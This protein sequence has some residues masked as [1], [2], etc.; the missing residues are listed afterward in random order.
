M[1]LLLPDITGPCWVVH[2]YG[3]ESVHGVKVNFNAVTHAVVWSSLWFNQEMAQLQMDK[4]KEQQQWMKAH[5]MPEDPPPS[6]VRFENPRAAISAMA[7]PP[8][9]DRSWEGKRAVRPNLPALIRT[10]VE[11]LREK[12]ASHTW[13]QSQEGTWITIK[14]QQLLGQRQVKVP[15]KLKKKT[16][17]LDLTTNVIAGHEAPHRPGSLGIPRS[18]DPPMPAPPIQV[19]TAGLILTHSGFKVASLTTNAVAPYSKA[20]N[21]RFW[22]RHVLTE[23]IEV[24]EPLRGLWAS[25]TGGGFSSWLS[26]PSRLRVRC[27]TGDELRFDDNDEKLLL[28]GKW[29]AVEIAAKRL[30]NT[31]WVNG[32]N[33]HLLDRWNPEPLGIEMESSGA[34]LLADVQ[35][36]QTEPTRTRPRLTPK[37][38]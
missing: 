7:N 4:I 31:A 2:H 5:K 12:Q 18:L 10:R 3:H 23:D 9:N 27:G 1:G 22:I 33:R 6:M 35:V 26:R 14:G 36:L 17:T 29:H 24:T 38:K 19:N 34:I 13:Q 37:M 16:E 30:K 11:E 8:F 28:D 15:G 25:R 32:T 21:L 20:C